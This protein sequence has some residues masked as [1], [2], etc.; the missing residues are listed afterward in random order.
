MSA[1]GN[2]AEIDG[3]CTKSL[4]E[5]ISLLF[6]KGKETYTADWINPIV[7]ENLYQNFENTRVEKHPPN[8]LPF[9]LKKKNVTG[10][11]TCVACMLLQVSYIS[12]LNLLE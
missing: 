9:V 5:A 6:S 10:K 8:Y 4:P 2:R 7:P 11:I 1:L 3:M 12:K